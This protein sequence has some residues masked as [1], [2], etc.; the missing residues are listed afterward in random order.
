MRNDRELQKAVLESLDFDPSINCSHIGVAVRGGMVTL[1]GH[2]ASLGERRAAAVGAGRVKG[3]K[4]VIDDITVELPGRCQTSDEV[5]AKRAHGRLASNRSVPTGRVHLEV[6]DGVVTLHGQVD[7][8]YQRLDAEADLHKLDG[9]RELRN[10]IAI[11]PPVKL[12]VVRTKVHEALARLAPFDTSRIAIK[13]EGTKVTLTGA[14]TSWHEKGM[15]ESAV[16]SVPGVTEVDNEV[17]VV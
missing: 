9:I 5:I 14:V 3:V 16:W 1:S 2:V 13:T 7:W 6:K 15:A 4:A 12:E 8:Q 11:K 17:A 10:E